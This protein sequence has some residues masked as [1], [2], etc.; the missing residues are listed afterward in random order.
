[1]DITSLG[2]LAVLALIDSTSFGTLLIPLWMMLAPRLRPSRLLLYLGVVCGFYF[3]VGLALLAGVDVLT[4]LSAG[5]GDSQVIRALQLAAG[6][7]L[8]VL[9]YSLDP[10]YHSIGRKKSE[11]QRGP[12]PRA[13]RWQARLTAADVSVRAV[14]VIAL[15]ATVLEVATMLPY[16]AAIGIINLSGQVAAVQVCLLAGYVVVMVLP[17]LVALALRLA[18]RRQVE[19]L[20]E[21][22]SAWMT[23]KAGSTVAWIVGIVGVLVALDAVGALLR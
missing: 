13:L 2:A 11:E 7:A 12:S 6:V 17:A 9:S 10:A 8:V 19:P 18:L 21:R 14:V 16:L 22:V 1:M 15:T 23:K 5:M 20:L 3:L 4:S